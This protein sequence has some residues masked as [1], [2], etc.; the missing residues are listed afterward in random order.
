MR[1]LGLFPNKYLGGLAPVGTVVVSQIFWQLNMDAQFSFKHF[2]WIFHFLAIMQVI[3]TTTGSRSRSRPPATIHKQQ[4][5]G[6]LSILHQSGSWMT[7]VDYGLQFSDGI[8]LG[9]QPGV[10]VQYPAAKEFG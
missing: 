6:V 7:A 5:V 4:Y 2:T 3:I 10:W 1:D 8:E 9:R